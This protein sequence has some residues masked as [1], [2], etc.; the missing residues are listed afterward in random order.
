MPVLMS[1]MVAGPQRLREAERELGRRQSG[2]GAA[3]EERRER[4]GGRGGAG[5]EVERERSGARGA[6]AGE[7]EQ[8]RS[9]GRG[10]AAGEVARSRGARERGRRGAAAWNRLKATE[11]RQRSPVCCLQGRSSDLQTPLHTL[12]VHM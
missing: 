5:A 6:A 11:R 3:G 10:G 4:S 12:G 9:S 7:E 2:R 1:A 8:V